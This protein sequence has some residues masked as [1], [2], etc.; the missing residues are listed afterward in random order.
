[1]VLIALLG[2]IVFLILYNLRTLDDNRLT[3]WLWVFSEINVL[4]IFLILTAGYVL[5]FGFTKLSIPEHK[6]IAFLF[7][8][9]FIATT[10][11]WSEPELIVDT[12][13]YFVQAK[14]LELYGIGYFVTEWGKEI[15]VWTDLPLIPLLYGL[16]FKFLGESRL[17]IQIFNTLLFSGTVVLTYLIGKQLWD[18]TVGLYGGLLLLGM[19]Y[20]LTQVPLMLVDV[21]TMFFLTLAI[22]TT[23]MALRQDGVLTIAAAAIAIT[24]AMLSKYSAWL[25]LSILPIIALCHLSIGRKRMMQRASMIALGAI[26]LV[27]IFIITKFD[28]VSEQ[29]KLLLSYQLPGLERWGESLGSTFLFQIHPFISLAAL[30]SVYVAI[31]KRDVVYAII[32]WLPLLVIILEINR[33]RYILVTLPMLALM[34]AYGVREIKNIRIS[35]FFVSSTVVSALVIAI[36]GYL[37]F[38]QNT[39]AS[40][41]K[42]AGKYLDSIDADRIEVVVLPQIRSSINPAVS[43]PLLDLYT[44]KDLV[45]RYDEKQVVTPVSIRKSPLRFTWQYKNPEYFK[46]D[47]S[48]S[49]ERIP[50]AIILCGYDQVLSDQ[51]MKKITGYRLARELAATDR[52]F[53]YRT[54]IRVYQP[55]F[56]T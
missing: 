32:C 9:S 8:S 14:H 26:I 23:I 33:S 56:V 24:L 4:T 29:L 52:V 28:V 43:V 5:A 18:R 27:G 3:S 22:F 35:R 13:R 42:Q 40:N 54:I 46:I 15:M 11:L 48:V 44:K 16:V 38:L 50:I 20:L 2:L 55:V 47:A 6:P 30:F 41:I 17:S 49:G 39:S 53:Q 25:M 10:F 19:P 21:P 51:I 36:F 12:S 37:P 31:K 1:M 45:F 34:A 7:L